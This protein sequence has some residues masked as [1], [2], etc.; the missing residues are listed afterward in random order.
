MLKGKLKLSPSKIKTPSKFGGKNFAFVCFRSEEDKENALKVLDGYNWKGRMFKAKSA[1]AITDPMLKRRLQQSGSKVTNT[2]SDDAATAKKSVLE[3][4]VP[5][6]NVPY[7]DQL[8][9]KETECIKQLHSYADAVKR[10]NCRLKK[11]IIEVQQKQSGLPCIWHGLKP[12][13]TTEAYRNKNEFAI[14]KNSEGKKVVGFRLGS[15]SD[16]TVEVGSIKGLPQ[17]P[18]RTQDAAES[19]EHYVQNSKYE[20]FSPEFYTGQFR[21][22]SVRL[23]VA[24]NELMLIVGLHT[25]E[26]PN[27]VNELKNDI[28]DYYSNREGKVLNVTSLYI[29]EMNKR[30]VGQQSNRIEH[31]YGSKY[32]TDCILGMRFRISAASFFQ[33]NTK[34]AEILY[35]MAV[36]MGKVNEN[37]TVL[38]ICCGTG[39]IGLSFAKHCKEVLGVEIIQE[40]VDD[41]KFNAETN[42]I[43]NCKFFAGNCD[44]Y[45]SSLVYQAANED[46]LAVI[47]PP[48]AGLREY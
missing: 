8:K 3:A 33:I 2:G 31:I 22:L 41:A 30:E 39:T 25:S 10:A 17:V 13:P 48:R 45:M 37:T 35:Q 16:G 23:S 34:A 11:S 4:T 32:I 19:F 26:I 18:Q 44:D 14:G 40:A 43:T 42:G 6:A 21:Q 7:S 20:V 28:I 1:K 15:Y 47:D 46:I 36:D 29:E 24:T 27:E 12:S 5:L 9:D 38:D